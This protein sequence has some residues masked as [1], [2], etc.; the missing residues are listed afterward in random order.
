V[1][2]RRGQRVFEERN[3]SL[4][5]ISI[6]ELKKILEK[7]KHMKGL[8]KQRLRKSFRNLCICFAICDIEKRPWIFLLKE[9][10]NLILKCKLSVH[11]M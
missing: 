8:I 2:Q 3:V 10:I 5:P 11:L 6:K 1:A 4:N 7:Y 9:F